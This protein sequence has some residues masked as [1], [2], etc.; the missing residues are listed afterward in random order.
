MCIDAGGMLPEPRNKEETDFLNDMG[1][2][3]WF[4]LGFTD[5]DAEDIWVWTSDGSP[6]TWM[7][8]MEDEP[9]GG[10]TQNCGAMVRNYPVTANT[11]SPVYG[12]AFCDNPNNMTIPVVCEKRKY[13]FITMK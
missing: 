1:T 5:H 3:I 11:T 2:A 4:Y 13:T 8:W 10:T 6:V 9:N 7:V 12:S